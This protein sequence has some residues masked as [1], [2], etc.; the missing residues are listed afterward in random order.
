MCNLLLLVLLGAL[1][2]IVSQ[3]HVVECVPE[4]SVCDCSF[5]DPLGIYYV[6]STTNLSV[7][8]ID[9]SCPSNKTCQPLKCYIWCVTDHHVG[10]NWQNISVLRF[11][12]GYHLGQEITNT[13]PLEVGSLEVTN[14]ASGAV[15]ILSLRIVLL[16]H[17]AL[18]LENITVK[19][20]SFSLSHFREAFVAIISCQF[21][22]VNISLSLLGVYI[23]DSLFVRTHFRALSDSSAAPMNISIVHC[24]FNASEVVIQAASVHVKD[25]K[26]CNSSSQSAL[27]LY[28]SELTLA[29]EVRFVNNCGINGGALALIGTNLN[30]GRYSSIYF[31]NNSAK[32]NGG[33]LFIDYPGILIDIISDDIIC[34]YK[35]LEFAGNESFL[36]YFVEFTGN[37]AGR[38]GHHVYG[39]SL[40]S[41]CTAAT[42]LLTDS[43]MKI[44]SYELVNE[45]VFKVDDPSYGGNYLSVVSG[46]PS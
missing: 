37:R 3:L 26:F 29:G 35:L 45:G 31:V 23:V 2:P 4:N 25:S 33:A 42:T 38:A 34:F 1:L 20:S 10:E 24:S 8:V 46:K 32:F 43:C 12:P 17:I 9:C 40:R 16:I 18:E 27:T 41:P 19:K 15:S 14:V 5:D 44:S 30:I 28:S 13:R 11:L 6:S 7:S 39:V 22:D 36:D 21:I